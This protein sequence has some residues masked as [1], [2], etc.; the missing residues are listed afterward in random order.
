[1]EIV[2]RLAKAG[3]IDRPEDILFLNPDEVEQVILGPEFHKLQHIAN[4]RRAQWEELRYKEPT[5][6]FTERASF[7]EAVRMDMV[8]SAEP[9]VIHVV[10]MEMPIDRPDLK[11][12]M[13]GVSTSPGET[14][15]LARVVM[16]TNSWAKCSPVKFW[17]APPLTRLGHRLL[18]W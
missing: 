5:P 15:G 14:D 10:G 1:M 7:E 17:S 8:P 3:T 18:G 11:A 13:R 9:I 16:D 4:R 12:D 2:R 6:V